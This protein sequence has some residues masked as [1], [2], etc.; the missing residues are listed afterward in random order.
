MSPDERNRQEPDDGVEY[1]ISE[2]YELP[3]DDPLVQQALA[4]LEREDQE[5]TQSRSWQRT[6]EN[7]YD[8]IPITVKQLDII[9]GCATAALVLVMIFIVLEALGIR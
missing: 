2:S 4:D 8:K 7:W 1:Q 5:K 6:K 9:I 3:E